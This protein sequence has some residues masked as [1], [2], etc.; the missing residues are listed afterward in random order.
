MEDSLLLKL[1]PLVMLIGLLVMIIAGV[2]SAYAFS[3]THDIKKSVILYLPI[4]VVITVIL[5][6]MGVPLIIGIGMMGVGIVA[7][8]Y[9]SNRFFYK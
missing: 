2:L 5:A 1:N 4:S 8:I 3:S 7:L 9:A 6:V